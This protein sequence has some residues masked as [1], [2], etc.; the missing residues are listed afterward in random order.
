MQTKTNRKNMRE[1]KLANGEKVNVV[2]EE[3]MREHDVVKEICN[4]ASDLNAKVKKIKEYIEKKVDVLLKDAAARHNEE[5]KGNAHLFTIDETRK[6]IVK[7][8]PRIKF[9]KEM[10]IAK[11]KYDI[12]LNNMQADTQLR[13]LVK[14]VFNVD[15]DGN[16]PKSK[17][18][19]LRN[20]ESDDEVKKEADA[21]VDKSIRK[22]IRK[23][24]ITFYEKDDKGNW[25]R[26][27][28]NFSE[29]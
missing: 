5:W 9:N 22:E 2:S 1:V 7:I 8:S 14:R 21:I 23:P 15:S 3:R 12:W 19:L 16:I 17:L 10:A 27:Q 26:I 25:S 24:Y 18:M 20:Y 4:M 11:Q 29:I 6:V 13:G 28:L